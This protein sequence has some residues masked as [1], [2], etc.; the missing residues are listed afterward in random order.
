MGLCRV[1]L[2][3]VRASGVPADLSLGC[4]GVIMLVFELDLV[5]C[6]FAV[7]FLWNLYCPER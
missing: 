1:W 7:V 5:F 6:N 4:G 3:V 2:F